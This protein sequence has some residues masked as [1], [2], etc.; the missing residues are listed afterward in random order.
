[1]STGKISWG[2]FSA[3]PHRLFFWS[4]AFYAALMGALWT[5]QQLT[6]YA[7]LLPR[8]GWM[9]AGPPEPMHWVIPA[10]VAHGVIMLYA[11]MGYYLA[12]FLLT[13]L[14][15]RLGVEP[16]GRGPLLALWGALL[17][18]SHGFWIGLFFNRELVAGALGLLLAAYA[19]LVWQL[20]GRLLRASRERTVLAPLLLAVTPAP[21][22][23]GLLLLAVLGVYAEGYRA[24]L[25]LGV[26]GFIMPL[27]LTVS[28][29]MVPFFTQV[30]APGVEVRRSAY[31]GWVVLGLCWMRWGLDG[32]GPVGA[33]GVA[34][35]A[36]LTVWTS[37]LFRWRFWR[38]PQPP[39]VRVLYLGQGWIVLGLA[40]FSWQAL[41]LW[42]GSGAVPPFGRAPLHA[43]LVGGVGS[44]L[45]G[46]ST[47][48]TLGQSGRAGDRMSVAGAL[49]L[50]I[51]GVALA[52]VAPEIAGYWWPAWAVQGFWSGGLWALVFGAWLVRIGPVLL[53][54]RADGKPG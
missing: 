38:A 19:C 40:L 41:A 27:V 49:F 8:I 6:L 13:I 23:L 28:H 3:A 30:Q 53:R 4:G 43:L 1:M 48:I 29:L 16:V 33:V 21:L 34:D 26:N 5:V 22:G 35:L 50:A 11:L 14:P 39:L 54:A 51:Q 7:P 20:W 18:G 31:G 15:R 10:G 37:E 52:R 9:G 46:I 12:G 47:R 32:F 42:F 36:L 24:V 17:A 44:L 25:V 2:N 45:L